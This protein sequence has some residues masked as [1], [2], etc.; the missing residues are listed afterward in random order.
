MTK[1]EVLKQYFG[2]STFRYGQNDIID[3][4]LNGRD[5]LV[6]MPTG[7]GKSMCYQVPALMLQG[8][9]IVISP[10][11]SLMKDQVEGLIQSGVSTTYINSSLTR[12]EYLSAT[13]YVMTGECKILYVAPERLTT[14]SFVNLCSKIK[15]PLIAVDEAHCVS[16]W[17]QDFRPSYLKINEFIN[18]LPVRPIIAAFTA[19][20]TDAVKRD[21]V[22]ILGLDNPFR[23][24]TGFDRPNLYFEVRKPKTSMKDSELYSILKD[25]NGRNA[26]IYCN[27]RKNVDKVFELLSQKKM[28]VAK[29]HAGLSDEERKKA[30][31][32]FLYDKVN[33]IVATNAFGMGIDKSDVS[34]VIH[35]NMP[36]DI[37]SY[38]QEAGRAG[39]DGSPA[40]CILLYSKSDVRTNNFMIDHSHDE[41]N[42]SNE[43]IEEMKER[44]RQRLKMMTFYSTTDKCL[45]K[46]M[47]RYFGEH[48]DDFCG[49][50]S[51][52]NSNYD[53]ADIT[54]FAQKILSCIFRMKQ[55]NVIAD[56]ETIV[57]TLIGKPHLQ[58]LSQISTFAIM[59]ND[60]VAD[61]EEVFDYLCHNGY[62]ALENGF[63]R[64]SELAENFIRQKRS[65]LMKKPKLHK[66]EIV[67][68]YSKSTQSSKIE[69]GMENAELMAILKDLRKNI[70]AVQS[71]PA[72]IVFS[73]ATLREM[74][75][76]EPVTMEEFLSVS[77]VGQQKADR[78]FKKFS[79]V[80]QEY[81]NL[82]IGN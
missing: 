64:L 48:S 4:I 29:Y 79:C 9:T 72:Y 6:V 66:Q 67:S 5:C 74:S 49:N 16:H 28:Q 52:C 27:T 58:A 69:S 54:I 63:C 41:S 2:H 23:I 57:D 15:I 62:I 47:L 46:F 1:N 38:Y 30:Q 59:K 82:K 53:T 68:S 44:D 65:L 75:V 61:I 26:I 32:D 21:I 50:C 22:D 81:K 73:D 76:K 18:T 7:A 39:R 80:I 78:Y 34:L 10:L 8:T 60:K 42:L 45:R 33:I 43:E 40:R 31:E 25:S 77:G 51:N 55:I 11:I 36:K 56:K 14:E 70:A 12:E 19:T 24:T 37:E 35:Y 71:V 13:N 3:S 20:A 17:G